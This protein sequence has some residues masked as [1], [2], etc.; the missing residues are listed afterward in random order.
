MA[1]EMSNVRWSLDVYGIGSKL[2][3]LR[4]RKRLTLSRLAGETGLSTALL[5]KLETDR[6]IPTLPTLATICQVFG[7]GLSYFFK[8]PDRH[9]VSITRRAQW[10]GSGPRPEPVRFTP[11]HPPL[12]EAPLTSQIIELAPDGSSYNPALG[13]DV[14]CVLYVLEGHLLIESGRMR[15]SLMAGDCAYI[16][17]QMAMTWGAGSKTRCIVLAVCPG[18]AAG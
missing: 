15:E 2:R 6:M 8:D 11:L 5:S 4:T 3:S 12:P 16:D 7:V 18:M 10:L 14:Q 17:S 13:G 1:R 9:T